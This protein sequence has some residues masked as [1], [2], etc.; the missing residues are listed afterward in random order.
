[1]MNKRVLFALVFGLLNISMLVAAPKKKPRVNDSDI[2]GVNQSAQQAPSNPFDSSDSGSNVDV[3]SDDEGPNHLAEF[4]AGFETV[5][6]STRAERSAAALRIQ[7]NWRMYAAK[8]QAADLWVHK[9]AHEALDGLLAGSLHGAQIIEHFRA[10]PK[11]IQMFVAIKF[12]DVLLKNINNSTDIK[13]KIKTNISP[14][15]CADLGTIIQY[16]MSNYVVLH[17]VLAQNIIPYQE[18]QELYLML[19]NS[20]FVVKIFELYRVLLHPLDDQT[21]RQFFDLIDQFEPMLQSFVRTLESSELQLFVE[22][23]LNI[24]V[25]MA[26]LRI[27]LEVDRNDFLEDMFLSNLGMLRAAFEELSGL[28]GLRE[29]KELF[30][31]VAEIFNELIQT[32]RRG[33]HLD[34]H[35]IPSVISRLMPLLQKYSEVF[36]RYLGCASVRFIFA[37]H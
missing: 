24:L 2:P 27:L 10:M 22:T 17:A 9:I 3:D 1:M 33:S 25:G 23:G 8:K 36:G 35:D 12:L 11:S 7:K 18:N 26:T 30:C 13:E 28:C 31:E 6:K 20:N 34:A 15:M 19:K 32:E 29:H 37:A 5:H 16:L 21:R 14:E 4:V